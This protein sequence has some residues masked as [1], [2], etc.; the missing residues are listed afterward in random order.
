MHHLSSLGAQVI[1][2]RRAAP[3]TFWSPRRRPEITA[4]WKVCSAATAFRSSSY[5]PGKPWWMAAAALAA[6]CA[7]I[8]APLFQAS[9]PPSA[10]AARPMGTLFNIPFAD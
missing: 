9:W 8:D 2:I 7:G 4:V 1:G 5:I 3:R 10:P 6:H